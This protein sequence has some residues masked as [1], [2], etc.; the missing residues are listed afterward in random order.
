MIRSV[1]W[2]VLLVVVFSATTAFR[3]LNLKNGFPDDHYVHLAGGWQMTFGEWPTRDFV[4]PGLPAMFA[5]SAAAQWLFGDTLYS[6]V[7]L[8][9]VAFGAAAAFTMLAVRQLTG[10]MILAL[11]AA[12]AEVA[13]V[14]RTYGYPKLL[15]YAVGFWLMARYAA[16]PTIV[17][18]ATMAAMVVL[19]FLFR[20]DHGLFLGT[21]GVLVAALSTPERNARVVLRSVGVFVA[22]VAVFLLP[23]LVFIE[24]YMGIGLYM[25]TGIE[26]S[27]AEAARQGH[28]WPSLFGENRMQVALLYEFYLIPLIALAVVAWGRQR[29]AIAQIVPI[30]VVGLMVN[31]GFI[32]EPLGTRL[33]DAIVPLVVLGAWLIGRAWAPGR[34]VQKDQPHAARPYTAYRLIAMAAS[35]VAFVV[36][37]AS[38]VRAGSTIEELDRAALFARWD[39][40][41]GRFGERADQYKTRF[42]DYLIPSGEVFRLVP[43]FNYLD[44]CTTREHRL[45]NVGFAVEVPYFARRAFAGGISYFAGYPAVP[46]LDQRVLTKMR[47]EVVPFVLIASEFAKEFPVRFPLT[48]RYVRVRYTPLLDVKIRDDLTMQILIDPNLPSRGRDQETGYPCFV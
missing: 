2:V 37:G 3:F 33:P 10:S 32:R 26:F 4:D 38:I 24:I 9:A 19:A 47:S 30:A 14:P 8:V 25:R 41:P 35:I 39:T 27:R 48:E 45:L 6:E 28:V 36:V 15:L 20:H 34:P 29:E 13:I 17:R 18:A 21:G 1:A 46:E 42:D 7:V 44:R 23:Y 16:R 43:F 31:Y 5:A 11:L 22:L 40:I 12:I